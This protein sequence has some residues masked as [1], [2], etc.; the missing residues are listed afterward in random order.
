MML[1]PRML[2]GWLHIT[3]RCQTV[4]AA[5]KVL[6]LECWSCA[7]PEPYMPAVHLLP[8]HALCH[9]TATL[10]MR[11]RHQLPPTIVAALMQALWPSP[12]RRLQHWVCRTWLD[13]RPGQRLATAT[14]GAVGAPKLLCALTPENWCKRWS[15]QHA[16]RGHTPQCHSTQQSTLHGGRAMRRQY[17]ARPSAWSVLDGGRNC[18]RPNAWCRQSRCKARAC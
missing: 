10:Q 2:I 9:R 13:Y 1:P 15:R 17:A 5:K 12:M 6:D 3:T 16:T 14:V 11:Y 18:P 4:D 8:R 7:A